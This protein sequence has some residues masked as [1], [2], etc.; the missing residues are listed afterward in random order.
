MRFSLPEPLT[1]SPWVKTD[2]ILSW[3]LERHISHS[4]SVLKL[5]NP[6]VEI[7]G[8]AMQNRSKRNSN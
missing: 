4:H 5:N 7:I 8:E 2:A 6:N 3:E 1:D